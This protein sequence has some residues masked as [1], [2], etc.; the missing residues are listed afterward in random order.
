MNDA[1]LTLSLQV[2]NKIVATAEYFPVSFE[3]VSLQPADIRISNMQIESED[4]L[5]FEL[6]SNAVA[7]FVLLE[8]DEKYRGRFTDNGFLLLPGTKLSASRTSQSSY[9]L[10][11]RPKGLLNIWDQER[12]VWHIY[13]CIYFVSF[14]F[15]LFYFIN[16]YLPPYVLAHHHFHCYYH[17]LLYYRI[18]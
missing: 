14:P 12:Y 11:L 15:V 3:Y 13:P 8:M 9:I 2:Q 6:E 7:P 16:P 18:V 5:K 10:Q 4:T 1:L 17:R